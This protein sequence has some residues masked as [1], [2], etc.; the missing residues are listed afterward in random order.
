MKYHLSISLS[1]LDQKNASIWVHYT[2]TG[3]QIWSSTLDPLWP[4]HGFDDEK[5]TFLQNLQIAVESSSDRVE[6][7]D[8]T[9]MILS[10]RSFSRCGHIWVR[11]VSDFGRNHGYLQINR[12]R[13]L[14]TVGSIDFTD[15]KFPFQTF[16]FS[17]LSHVDLLSFWPK[18]YR[19]LQELNVNTYWF[20]VR[21]D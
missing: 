18:P 15:A 2:H 11:F 21:N 4:K 12:S 14:E 16:I 19:Y 9:G 10:F 6:R 13:T 1:S 20:F 5:W 17:G 8:F 7:T 3:V